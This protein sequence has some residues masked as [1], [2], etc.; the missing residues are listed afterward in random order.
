MEK[1][2]NTPAYVSGFYRSIFG[3]F[4]T[5]YVLVAIPCLDWVDQEFGSCTARETFLT[6]LHWTVENEHVC[7]H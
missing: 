4:N 1:G 3:A 2:S 6:E 5:I 7:G